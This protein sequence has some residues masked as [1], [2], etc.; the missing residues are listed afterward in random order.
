MKFLCHDRG[1]GGRGSCGSLTRTS[2]ALFI[3][4]LKFRASLAPCKLSPSICRV[5]RRTEPEVLTKVSRHS[6]DNPTGSDTGR[7]S[8]RR[9]SVEPTREANRSVLRNIM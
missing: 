8:R 1:E 5:L 9:K 4:T 2:L 7:P 3:V 6:E